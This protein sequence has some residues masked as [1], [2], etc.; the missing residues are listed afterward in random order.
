MLKVQLCRTEHVAK[1]D[2]LAVESGVADVLSYA[3]GCF[4]LVGGGVL[5]TG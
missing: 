1:R 3:P 5:E 2:L 4:R